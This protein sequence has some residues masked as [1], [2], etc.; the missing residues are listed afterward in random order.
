MDVTGHRDQRP[1]RG[2][3]RRFRRP[4][5]WP[6]TPSNVGEFAVVA[7]NDQPTYITAATTAARRDD[8]AITLNETNKYATLAGAP[9]TVYKACKVDGGSLRGG[10]GR[11]GRCGSASTAGY[12]PQLASWSPSAPARAA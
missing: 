8:T 4:S 12:A 6:A 1:G 2:C 7:G 10:L 5:P 11:S 3:G 9:L